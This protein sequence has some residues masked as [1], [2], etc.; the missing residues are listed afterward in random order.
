MCSVHFSIQHWYT[1]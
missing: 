1:I